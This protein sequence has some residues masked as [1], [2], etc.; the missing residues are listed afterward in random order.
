MRLALAAEHWCFGAV[1]S[2]E[3]QD[4]LLDAIKSE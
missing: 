4:R 2:E 1:T 3:S